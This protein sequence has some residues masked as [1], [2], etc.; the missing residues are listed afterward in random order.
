LQAPHHDTAPAY[1]LPAL[2]T[3]F[4]G[5]VNLIYIDPGMA[6]RQP[7]DVGQVLWFRGLRWGYH[8]SSPSHTQDLR[9]GAESDN[10]MHLRCL[11]RA[12][13]LCQRLG[14]DPAGDT[15]PD[16]PKR[17]RW[18]TY[19]RIMDKLVAADDIATSD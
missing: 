17:M 8:H 4:A 11:R 19:N 1:V 6:A 2:L 13:K 10:R 3:E 15:Y 5:K 9:L 16:K 12:R 14:G 18:T 7:G